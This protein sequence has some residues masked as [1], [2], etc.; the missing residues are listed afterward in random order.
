MRVGTA[1]RG[2]RGW[3]PLGASVAPSN[4]TTHSGGLRRNDTRAAGRKPPHT[5]TTHRCVSIQRH[6]VGRRDVTRRADGHARLRQRERQRHAR[7]R[8]AWRTQDTL[9]PT[10]PSPQE[11]N[12]RIGMVLGGEDEVREGGPD[13]QGRERPQPSQVGPGRGGRQ[14]RHCTRVGEVEGGHAV[15]LCVNNTQG[16]EGRGGKPRRHAHAKARSS[17]SGSST[18]FVIIVGGPGGEAGK[19]ARTGKMNRVSVASRASC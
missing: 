11:A 5:T 2:G 10:T 7:R 15:Q 12:R 16:G 8:S 6:A 9:S 1:P 17:G 19:A 18:S 3:G 14:V 4:I 13:T